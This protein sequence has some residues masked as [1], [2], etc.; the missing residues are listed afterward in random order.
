MLLLSKRSPYFAKRMSFS[1]LNNIGIIL[2]TLP[3]RMGEKKWGQK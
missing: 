2:L 1:E 3:F